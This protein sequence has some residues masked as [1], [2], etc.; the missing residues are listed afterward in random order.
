MKTYTK[1][2]L[3]LV[4]LA[5]LIASAAPASADPALREQRDINGDFVIIGNTLAHECELTGMPPI[6]DPVVVRRVSRLKCTA[7]CLWRA[8][9]D[10]AKRWP[11]SRSCRPSAQHR[12]A[13]P[14]DDAES[15]TRA[16]IGR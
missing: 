14:T 8:T 5:L 2:A 4:V 13:R 12:D 6:P 1:L 7:R 10:A 16:C 11:T 3:A 15:C 9:S